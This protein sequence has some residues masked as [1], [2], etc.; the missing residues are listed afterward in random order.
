MP[1]ASVHIWAREFED[2][3]YENGRDTRTKRYFTSAHVAL[4]EPDLLA[5]IN[6]AAPKPRAELPD[7]GAAKVTGT[8]DNLPHLL[9]VLAARP[10]AWAYGVLEPTTITGPRSAKTVLA[11]F[12]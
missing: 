7:G 5:P 6:L 1:T 3:D 2:H 4:A 11:H 12:P 10:T 8:Q 9:A